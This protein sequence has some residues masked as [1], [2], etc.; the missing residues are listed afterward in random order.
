MP[1][2]KQQANKTR[3]FRFSSAAI[4]LMN[5]VLL[6]QATYYDIFTTSTVPISN[7]LTYDSYVYSCL[8]ANRCHKLTRILF[9]NMSV[10]QIISINKDRICLLPIVQA[11]EVCSFD[12]IL[13]E[14]D[15]LYRGL[16]NNS[17][18][19][20]SDSED[21]K[22]FIESKETKDDKYRLDFAF[23]PEIRDTGGAVI[24][25]IFPTYGDL[26]EIQVFVAS[27]DLEKTLKKEAAGIP[28]SN[29]SIQFN[30]KMYFRYEQLH[31]FLTTF[32]R[33]QNIQP[34]ESKQLLT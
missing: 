24:K 34:L 29:N 9:S 20:F 21:L 8:L 30:K 6:L 32:Y 19:F 26:V 10:Q 11:H 5:E 3:H 28:I 14:Y 27:N 7:W 2:N 15:R 25:P 33:V 12:C 4:D 18:G 1:A 31:N 16:E 23:V 13:I 22:F 17:K